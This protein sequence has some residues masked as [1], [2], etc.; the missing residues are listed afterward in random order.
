MSV[1]LE[2]TA[3]RGSARFVVRELSGRVALVRYALRSS[4]RPIYLRHNTA[5]P[6]VLAEVFYARHYDLPDPVA[7]FLGGLGRPPEIV[8]LGANIG[9]FGVLMLDRFPGARITAF[10]PDRSNAEIHRRAMAEN[11]ARRQLAARSGRGVQSRRP[12]VFSVRR[13]L[14]VPDRSCGRK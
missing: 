7:R 1:V 2:S 14:A 8:D 13:V 9:L 3:V 5:D 6:L 4:G 10:E 11:D 12:C